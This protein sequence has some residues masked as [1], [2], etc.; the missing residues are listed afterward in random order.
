M[1]G[2]FKPK[3]KTLTVVDSLSIQNTEEVGFQ[4]TVSFSH[5]ARHQRL[6]EI[7]DQLGI[8]TPRIF[9]LYYVVPE[10]KFSEYKFQ[11]YMKTRGKGTMQAIGVVK[12][13]EQWVLLLP[14]VGP[15]NK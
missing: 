11:K 9:R 6:K 7:L 12:Q 13:V 14:I 3:S 1:K 8:K 4:V 2:Y 15:R 10:D 5:R